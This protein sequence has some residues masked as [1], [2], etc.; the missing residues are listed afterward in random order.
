MAIQFSPEEILETIRMVQMDNL[1]IRTIT[2]GISL[3][4][5][6]DTSLEAA[7]KKAYEKICRTA[8]RLVAVG[9][10]I[11]REY[12][13]PI[14]NKR[15]S[16]TPVSLIAEASGSN[17]YV[18]F[19]EYL[20]RAA[21]EVGVNFLG[22]FSALVHKVTTPGDDALI[23]SL[24]EALARTER[25]CAS[26]NVATTR[27][28]INMDAVAR[29]GEIIVATAARTADR[30]GIGCAKLVVF[31]N[32]VEDNP[33]MA[34]AFHGIGEPDCVV[35]VGVSGPGVVANAVEAEPHADFGA[36]ASVIKRT[37][38]KITRMGELVGR[39]A[40]A[41]LGVP[42]GIVDLSL[43]PTPAPGDSVA[44]VLQAMGLER[45]GTHGST[46]ALALLNDGQERRRHG[47]EL[48]RRPLGS[49]HSGVRGRR[50]D[51]RRSRGHTDIRQAGSDDL[52][53]LR[54]PRHDRGARRYALH[55]HRGNH[56]RR[57]RD[58]HDQSQ[59]DG[60]AA[61]SRARQERRRRRV[62]RRVARPRAR[63]R[64]AS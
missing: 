6:A 39:A 37:A 63:D 56:R 30:D 4:N 43:A 62:V 44:R 16:V 21:A 52:R 11:E 28:G 47:V 9:E 25:V 19:A 8:S 64:V 54:R 34:G 57:S 50:D 20:E 17:D 12:G 40:S 42:F 35:N 29:M 2:M 13:I 49:V 61:D 15:V 26:V 14:I 22:G 18:L 46:A 41:K 24:P 31:C 5:C 7:A 55:H 53:L 33:F 1:D 59:D 48:R 51:R 36:L 58:R 10:E 45:I 3:R 60:G 23:A 27:A 32:A 38:F